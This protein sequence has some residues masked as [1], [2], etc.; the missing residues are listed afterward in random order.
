MCVVLHVTLMHETGMFGFS[1]CQNGR[2]RMA[3]RPAGLFVAQYHLLSFGR[4]ACVCVDCITNIR[5]CQCNET[6]ETLD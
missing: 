3:L 2:W 1:L 5:L 4:G 6:S